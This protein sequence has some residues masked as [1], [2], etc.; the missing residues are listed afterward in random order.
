MKE[1]IVLLFTFAILAVQYHLGLMRKL[2][3]GAVLPA[4]LAALFLAISF[5][6]QT[7]EY[8]LTGL[9]CV[10]AAVLRSASAIGWGARRHGTCERRH[11]SG[12]GGGRRSPPR[13]GFLARFSSKCGGDFP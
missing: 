9:L 2:G 4:A 13:A 1:I 10:L 3:F 5:W 12:E 11:P 8:G 7:T 6:E